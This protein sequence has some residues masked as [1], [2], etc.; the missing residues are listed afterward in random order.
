[1]RIDSVAAVR[2]QATSGTSSWIAK[3]HQHAIAQ[4]LG[5]MPVVAR[6]DLMTGGLIGHHASMIVFGIELL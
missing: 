1:M 3:V 4:I 6:D 2:G 5:N